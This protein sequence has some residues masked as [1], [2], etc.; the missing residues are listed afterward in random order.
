MKANMNGKI[1]QIAYILVNKRISDRFFM[2]KNDAPSKIKDST[3]DSF[4]N[5]LRG[6]II[7]DRIT[8]KY[9][10]FYMVSQYVSQGTCT[11]THYTVLYNTTTIEV[12]D[13]WLMTYYQCYNY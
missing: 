2:N 5:P 11:P 1:P 13:I 4:I 10:D 8:S 6:T 7:S 12:E 3:S 9:F